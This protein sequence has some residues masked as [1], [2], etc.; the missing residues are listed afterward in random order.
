[1]TNLKAKI[2]ASSASDTSY[3]QRSFEAIALRKNQ[4]YYVHDID[5]AISES[6]L[7]KS[8]QGGFIEANNSSK[9][10]DKVKSAPATPPNSSTADYKRLTSDSISSFSGWVANKSVAATR[11]FNLSEFAGNGLI[12][13]SAINYTGPLGAD[14]KDAQSF[15]HNF[16]ASFNT[17]YRDH[18]DGRFEGRNENVEVRTDVWA[19]CQLDAG[20]TS[21]DR[22]DWY[23]VRTSL[24]CHNE[25]LN[26]QNT[27]DDNKY[28]SPYFDYCYATVKLADGDSGAGLD[29][30]AQDS[31]P[32]NAAGSTSFTTGMSVSIGGNVGFNMSGPTGGVSGGVTFSESTTR[33]IPDIGVNFTKDDTNK[34]YDWKYTTPTLTPGWSGFYTKCDDPKD[35]QKRM[36]IFDT[37][38][39]YTMKSDYGE[40][41]GTVELRTDASVR[42]TFITGW[43]SG[44]LD[45]TL[46]WYW[47]YSTTNIH[48]YDSVKKPS[49]SK[50]DYIMMFDAPTGSTA[51][52]IDLWNNVLKEYISDWNSKEMYYAVGDASL[53]TVAENYFASVKQ[54]IQATKD[55]LKGRGFEGTFT[56]YIKPDST[57]TKL[58]SFSETF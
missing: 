39:V 34:T 18:Y 17:S 24:I 13:Q 26:V 9:T 6:A 1:M 7:G 31:S 30:R 33:S 36:A 16:T 46:N 20:S 57:S 48:Y 25:Q 29:L 14:P 3:L 51:E 15:I 11:S 45:T 56:F 2:D 52:K 43:L 53:N 40:S 28:V 5:E 10:L 55:V 54:K 44:F 4:I 21:A 27:W 41:A 58:G 35:I 22:K 19:F 49:N 37:Y 8:Q 50:A 23:Y 12:S 38:G 47:Y 32:Q 42:L